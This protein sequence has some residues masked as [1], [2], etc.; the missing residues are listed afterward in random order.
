MALE[1]KVQRSGE[2]LL[3]R[4]R[5][6]SEQEVRRFV[7][8]L[9]TA[10]AMERATALDADRRVAEVEREKALRAEGGRVR[11][12]V[13]KTWAAKLRMVNDNARAEAERQLAEKVAS[14]RGEGQRV[15]EAALEAAR[16]EADRTLGLRIA[17]VREEAERT[18]VAELESVSVPAPAPATALEPV[19]PEPATDETLTRL[20]DG[21]RRL[22]L[23]V[24]L[25]DAL[26]TLAELVGNEVPRAAVLTVQGDRVRGWRFVGFGPGLDDDPAHRVDMEYGE[27]GIVGRAIVSGDVCSVVSGPDGVPGNGEPAFTTLPAGVH[28]LA[29]PVRVGGQVM[30]VVYGDDA[31]RRPAVGWRNS[32]E[33][34][35]RH[36]GHCLEALTAA[37]AAQLALQDTS[38][39]I[40]GD[41]GP[42]LPFDD[43]DDERPTPGP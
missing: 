41:D 27:A 25:T 23:A 9:L 14:V 34:L 43:V 10:A 40:P 20:L 11:A 38:S 19:S 42:T 17:R 13:E 15:L 37:R 1:D 33:V 29:V 18:I 2:Q 30:A 28:A 39:L 31:E 7:S 8:E 4:I 12:E 21:V 5:Q 35:A 22:D 3:Q 32:L 36:A 24:R 6:H 26:D 16:L